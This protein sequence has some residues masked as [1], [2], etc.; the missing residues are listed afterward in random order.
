MA[1]SRIKIAV[2]G[3]SGLIGKRHCQHVAESPRA[4]L[5][6]IVD[7]SPA[8]TGIAVSLKVPL[9]TS[10]DALL[11]SD[12]KPEAAIVCTPNHTHARSPLH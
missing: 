11:K 5:C 1:D 12:D 6:A 9:Y 4:D 2:V 10:I 7:P 8:A 3:G